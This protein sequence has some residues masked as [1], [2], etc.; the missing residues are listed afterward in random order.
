[1][2]AFL[3]ALLLPARERF[4][5]VEEEGFPLEGVPGFRARS[6]PEDAFILRH[7]GQ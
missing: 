3:N 2:S 4:S 5:L 7:L 1:M 6:S